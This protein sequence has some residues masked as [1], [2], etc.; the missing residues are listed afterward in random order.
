MRTEIGVFC[1]IVMALLME[2]G[3]IGYDVAAVAE[4]R[5]PSS[6]IECNR[7]NVEACRELKVFLLRDL[8]NQKYDKQTLKVMRKIILEWE[9]KG[10]K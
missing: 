3:L 10:A 8:P 9:P 2:C 1:L 4:S 7:G 5:K 6:V